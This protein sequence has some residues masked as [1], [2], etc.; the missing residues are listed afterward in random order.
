MAYVDWMIEGDKIAACNCSFGCPCE[1]NGLP[2]SDVCEGLECMEIAHGHFGDVRLDGLRFAAWFHWPGPVHLGGGSCQGFIDERADDGQREAIIKIL[3]GEE[4]EPNT[5][6]NIYGSTMEKE[7]DL[8]YSAIEF[9]CDIDGR[10]ARFD[11][12]GHLE[13]NIKPILNPV[14][15]APHRA[16]IRLPEGWEFREAE[17]ANGSFRGAG[18]ISY[19]HADCYGALFHVAY[20]PHGIIA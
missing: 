4:Q 9:A 17:V 13:L 12:P 11:I 10:M 8:V 20:G 14:T 15:S 1:F 5:V 7:F 18:E 3:S 19:D 6:F 16:Q 2:T